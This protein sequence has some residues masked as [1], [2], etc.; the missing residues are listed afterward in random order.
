MQLEKESD[1]SDFLTGA[2]MTDA[3]IIVQSHIH[4]VTT[5]LTT[6]EHVGKKSTEAHESFSTFNRQNFGPTGPR[7]FGV[8]WP[9][10]RDIHKLSV[11]VVFL[12]PM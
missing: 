5:E 2:A 12:C 11:L 7:L 8:E 6:C 1:R 3:T 10:F 4:N 9:I